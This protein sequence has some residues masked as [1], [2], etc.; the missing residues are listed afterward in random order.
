MPAVPGSAGHLTTLGTFALTVDAASIPEPATKKARTLLVYLILNQLQVIPRERL[1]ELLWPE[2]EPER[3]RASLSTALW[4][5]RKTLKGAGV[6]AE[7]TIQSTNSALTWLRPVTS[8]VIEFRE[9]AKAGDVKSKSRAVQLYGGD[10]LED[11][12][13]EWSLSQRESLAR[14]YEQLLADLLQ[15]SPDVDV[16]HRLLSRDPYNEDAYVTLIDAQLE[17]NRSFAAVDLIERCRKALAELGTKTSDAFDRKYANIDALLKPRARDFSLPMMGRN[18]EF[19]L[20]W[21]RVADLRDA[22]GSLTIVNGEPGIGK[23][24]LLRQLAKAAGPAV[25]V[26]YVQAIG[27]DAR[28]YGPWGRF[29]TEITGESFDNFLQT[30]ARAPVAL[31]SRIAQALKTGILLVIDD[32]QYFQAEA[33]EVFTQLVALARERHA[34]VVATRPERLTAIRMAVGKKEPLEIQ[35]SPIARADFNAGVE[36]ATGLQQPLLADSVYARSLGQPLFFTEIFKSL[37][38]DGLLERENSTWRYTGSSA[39]IDIPETLRT[40]IENRL[41]SRGN[42]ANEIACIL[43]LDPD[44]SLSDFTSVTQA[45]E[46]SVIDSLDE[47]LVTQVIEESNV[48]PH[49][50]FSHDLLREVAATLLSRPNRQRFHR[51]FAEHL[52][53]AVAQNSNARLAGHFAG[54]DEHEAAA[55]SYLAAARDALEVQAWQRAVEYSN[56][57]LSHCAHLA[58]SSV[59]SATAAAI[60][61]EKAQALSDGLEFNQAVAVASQAL[62]AAESAGQPQLIARALLARTYPIAAQG[63]GAQTLFEIRRAQELAQFC[64]DAKIELRALQLQTAVEFDLFHFDDAA[65]SSAK[66]YRS[67]IEQQEWLTAGVMLH[68]TVVIDAARWHFQS[69]ALAAEKAAEIVRRGGRSAQASH[70]VATARLAYL[71]DD[72]NTAS[73]LVGEGVRLLSEFREHPEPHRQVEISATLLDLYLS[74]LN[75]LFAL[76]AGDANG[77]LAFAEHALEASNGRLSVARVL[78]IEC[79]LARNG[80]QDLQLAEK[81]FATLPKDYSPNALGFSSSGKTCAAVLAARR[82][83][84]AAAKVLSDAL[85][86]VER[87]AAV[88]PLNCDMICERLRDAAASIGDDAVASRAEKLQREYA[89]RRQSAAGPRW[90]RGAFLH[91]G[92]RPP[93]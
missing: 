49:Y 91:L 35:L 52:Q 10:F 33:F 13:E 90:Q 6:D 18:S 39:P 29:Y 30:T 43:A 84:P 73:A 85:D 16:A 86:E 9:L 81:H 59:H 69:S 40:A 78:A 57:A 36:Q 15:S 46:E 89:L 58:P 38:R 83:D 70:Y 54:C 64:G 47:L 68:Y 8:D 19:E 21:E 2:A 55:Q 93:V 50:R 14:Q 72:R 11:D 88:R 20:L 62:M 77:A 75:G 24:T 4:S 76:H 67:A 37:L 66:G 45:S 17:S 1:L 48:G 60:G 71:L 61:C 26:H 51:R 27:G 82:Q 87:N 44:A 80:P 12:Y 5:V 56:E 32:A 53:G 22:A 79:L 25:P 42:A 31:G 7:A 34:A 41:R 28:P 23:S 3:A 92:A 65:A 63:E 74:Y